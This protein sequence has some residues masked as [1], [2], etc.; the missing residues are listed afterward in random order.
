M[1]EVA[2]T[3][4]MTGVD[5]NSAGE[6]LY[7]WDDQF[8]PDE[9]LRLTNG[10]VE[11]VVVAAGDVLGDKTVLFL[12]FDADSLTDSRQVVFNI[13]YEETPGGD[14]LSA[15]FLATPNMP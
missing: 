4:E 14:R 12:G 6:V 3:S 8:S 11:V 2:A 10:S 1:T 5:I 13:T 7:H 9:E 15:V